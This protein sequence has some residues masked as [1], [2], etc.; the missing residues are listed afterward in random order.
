MQY[1]S[2]NI[3]FFHGI[4]LLL[5]LSC[6]AAW[7]AGGGPAPGSLDGT[8]GSGGK[9]ITDLGS[10]YEYGT[11]VAVQTDGKIVVVGSVSATNTFDHNLAVVRYTAAG[12]LDGGFGSN[13]V[14]II[15]LGAT[16][17][18]KCSVVIQSNGGIIV[19]CSTSSNSSAFSSTINRLTSTGA[20][21]S[22]F[23][24]NGV[25]TTDI[26]IQGRFQAPSAKSAA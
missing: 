25:V 2:S 22:N 21:D 6:S 3:R 23:G 13:G 10:A 5:A 24:S 19:G 14:T 4:C 15:P 16:Y 17:S 20:V 11:G 26:N 8:F 1:T 7:G 18:P 9:V 12:I